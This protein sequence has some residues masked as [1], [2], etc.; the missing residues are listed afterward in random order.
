MKRKSKVCRG[1][2]TERSGKLRQVIERHLMFSCMVSQGREEGVLDVTTERK[3]TE[4]KDGIVRRGKVMKERIG[5]QDVER[6]T[7]KGK[8]RTERRGRKDDEG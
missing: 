6:Y 5:K 4:E 1:E 8:D 3:D 2:D 7:L